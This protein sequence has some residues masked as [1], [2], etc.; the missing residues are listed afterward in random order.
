MI[1]VV[2]PAT[3]DPQNK[4]HKVESF[5]EDFKKLC[6][7]LYAPQK[8]VAIDERTVKSCHG[9]GFR[10]FIKD[11]PTKWGIKLWV[12]ADSSNVYTVNFNIY[13]AR[14]AGQTIGE[15]S[16]NMLS[17]HASHGPLLWEGIPIF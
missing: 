7:E 6:K 1:H 15:H 11:K 8:Y 9:S 16:L 13:I 10:Q 14:A 12:L 3:E 5:I 2:D 4:L 17:C